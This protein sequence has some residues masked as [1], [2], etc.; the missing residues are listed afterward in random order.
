LNNEHSGKK[1][2]KKGLQEKRVKEGDEKLLE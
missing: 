1:S 2:K